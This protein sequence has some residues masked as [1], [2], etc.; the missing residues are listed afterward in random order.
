MSLAAFRIQLLLTVAIASNSAMAISPP[1][2]QEVH[3]VLSPDG[4]QRLVANPRELT[5][6]RAQNWASQGVEGWAYDRQVPGTLPLYR[7]FD[8]ASQAYLY[9]TKREVREASVEAGLA[10][11]GIEAFVFGEPVPRSVQLIHLHNANGRMH[12]FTTSKA[13]LPGYTSEKIDAYLLNSPNVPY[14][15]IREPTTEGPRR[16]TMLVLHGGGWQTL[17]ITSVVGPRT[18]N[19][20]EIWRGRGWRTVATTYHPS[21]V[22]AG[23]PGAALWIGDA[24]SIPGSTLHSIEDVLDFY[25]QARSRWWARDETVCASGQSAGGHLALLLAAN[26]PSLACAIVQAGPTHLRALEE[27]TSEGGPASVA[28]LIA[29]AAFGAHRI[30]DAELSP[31]LL[32]ARIQAPVLLA[33]GADDLVVPASQMARLQ[34]TSANVQAA[35]TLPPPPDG[36]PGVVFVHTLVATTAVASYR[37]AE[38][39]FVK[40]VLP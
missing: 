16:G 28:W 24:P 27:P 26:R 8:P 7:L 15:E 5:E 32:G 22:A 2:V 19:E 39:E 3:R 20:V 14:F 17:G 40:K 6:L 9:T 21:R 23:F 11:D 13:D 12:V 4:T 30:D 31:A 35:L 1:V 33:T 25:D 37:A 10:R 36:D 29:N 38:E 34:A 18:N